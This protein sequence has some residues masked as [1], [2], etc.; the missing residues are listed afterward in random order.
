MKYGRKFSVERK[1]QQ[2]MILFLGDIFKNL[3]EYEFHILLA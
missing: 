3:I 2:K 1:I